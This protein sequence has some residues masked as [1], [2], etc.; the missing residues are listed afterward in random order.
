MYMYTINDFILQFTYTHT[1]ICLTGYFNS[2]IQELAPYI[3]IYI[4]G[5][6]QKSIFTINFAMFILTLIYI[7]QA[8]AFM[9]KHTM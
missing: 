6:Q 7:D 4:M 8:P 9:I 5:T 2:D 3:I 1:H